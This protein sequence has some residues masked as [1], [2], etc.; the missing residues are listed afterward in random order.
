MAVCLSPN[1]QDQSQTNTRA[2]ALRVGTA[3]GVYALQRANAKDQWELVGQSLED[4]HI[5]SLLYEPRSGLLFAG[6]H[7]HGLFA[8]ADEGRSWEERTDGLSSTHVFTLAAQERDGQVVLYA[9]TEPAALHRSFDLGRTWHELPSLRDVPVT[10]RWTFPAPPHVAHVKR[11]TFDPRDPGSFFVCVEQGALLKTTDDGRSWR[12]I[13]EFDRPD[14]V[15]KFDC[16]RLVA[17]HRNPDVLYLAT[18]EGLT[19][20]SDGGAHW[21]HLGAD[22]RIRYP[23]GLL[24]DPR[25]ERVVYVSGAADIPPGW[26]SGPANPAIMRSRDGGETWEELRTGLPQEIVGS[27]EALSLHR[28]GNHIALYAGTAV[29][30]IYGSEDGGGSWYTVATGLP[31]I[32]KGGHYRAFLQEDQ[33]AGARR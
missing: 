2:T 21:D 16:H 4:R 28:W 27:I 11:V 33:M 8:S 25:D 10:D 6:V 5:S 15:Y 17:D 3:H 29:G 7:G 26:R 30:H 12:V 22:V 24:V 19:K 23:D 20:S 18:G 1:G 32:S 9:G 13:D 31:P 14:D